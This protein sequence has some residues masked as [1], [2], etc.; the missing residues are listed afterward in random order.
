[1]LLASAPA[2]AGALACLAEVALTRGALEDSE[3]HVAEAMAVLAR[4]GSLEEFESFV[5]LAQLDVIVARG[6]L[7][8]ARDVAR[9]ARAS[10]ERRLSAI[11]DDE[12]RARLVSVVPDHH[13]LASRCAVLLGRSEIIAI[14]TDRPDPEPSGTA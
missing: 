12:A 4:H 2:R 8:S 9:A 11:E 13:A 3:H 10:L 7:P 6:D 5:W 14:A 1:V